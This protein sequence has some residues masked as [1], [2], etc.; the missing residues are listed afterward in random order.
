M[1]TNKR[2]TEAGQALGIFLLILVVIIVAVGIAS[3]LSGNTTMLDLYNG[4]GDL[5]K[6][7]Q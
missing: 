1:S 2:N 3:L 4:A 7:V 6:S 5:A